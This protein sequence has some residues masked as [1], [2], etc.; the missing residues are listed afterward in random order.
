VIPLQ[1]IL[2]VVVGWVQSQQQE[3]LEYLRAENRILKAQLRG[4]R[5]RLTVQE[6]RQLAVLGQRLGRRLLTTFATIVAPDT[7]ATFQDILH[8]HGRVFANPSKGQL[9]DSRNS[10]YGLA[11]CSR[12]GAVRFSES[13]PP[14]TRG[15]RIRPV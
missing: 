5:L 3:A 8:F 11:V 6:R 13:L 1:L 7:S 14:R 10:G 4:R 15:A 2:A 12:D 9:I